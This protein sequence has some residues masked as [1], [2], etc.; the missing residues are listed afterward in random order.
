MRFIETF[1]VPDTPPDITCYH[2]KGDVYT[3]SWK[4]GLVNIHSLSKLFIPNLSNCCFSVYMFHSVIR[5][6]EWLFLKLCSDLFVISLMVTSLKEE[7]IQRKNFLQLFWTFL[8]N[9]ILTKL[10]GS[11]TCLGSWPTSIVEHFY[12]NSCW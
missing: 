5:R 9:I 1:L 3:I 8:A 4:V 10:K 6:T 2:E 7:N 11:E 12:E